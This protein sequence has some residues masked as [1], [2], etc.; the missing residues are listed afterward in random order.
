MRQEAV[1][2]LSSLVLLASSGGGRAQ[3]GVVLEH[4]RIT[5]QFFVTIRDLQS[6]HGLDWIPKSKG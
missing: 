4:E 3:A 2:D 1:V 6:G 5:E